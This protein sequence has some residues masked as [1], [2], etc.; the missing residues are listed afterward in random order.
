[1][2]ECPHHLWLCRVKQDYLV[3]YPHLLKR[4]STSTRARAGTSA[5]TRASASA[6]A[7]DSTIATASSSTWEL[8]KIA[9]FLH[10]HHLRVHEVQ[11]KIFYQLGGFECPYH[12]W[13]SKP[14]KLHSCLSKI[15]IHRPLHLV[16]I[17]RQKAKS[18]TRVTLTS[19]QQ[20]RPSSDVQQQGPS[21]MSL[22]SDVT[23]S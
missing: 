22:C 21:M 19:L 2:F 14:L 20:V 17:L 6:S 4:A 16:I 7:R 3:W 13:L 15:M 18:T 5:S 12:L 10:C 1:M 9:K 11:K 23:R 8:G